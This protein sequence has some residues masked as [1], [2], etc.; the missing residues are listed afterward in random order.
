MSGETIKKIRS[1]LLQNQNPVYTSGRKGEYTFFGMFRLF[2][3]NIAAVVLFLMFLVFP[4]KTVRSFG[5]KWL[6]YWYNQR[7]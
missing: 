7:R 4:K 5:K 6:G 1:A 3:S 2:Y